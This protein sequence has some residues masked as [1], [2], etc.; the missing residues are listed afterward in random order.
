MGWKFYLIKLPTAEL[1]AIERLGKSPLT[2]N[3]R[4]VVTTLVPS[5]YDALFLQVTRTTLKAW[6]NSNF[7][8]IPSS[9][10]ELAALGCL[11]YQ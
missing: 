3:G 5:F 6:M 7:I 1:A 9:I 8:K 11:K 4:D 10:T 2:Y